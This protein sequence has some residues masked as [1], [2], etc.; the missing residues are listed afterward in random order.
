M[1]RERVV[2]LVGGDAAA[3]GEAARALEDAG[4]RAAVFVGDPAAADERAALVEMVE[5]L[6]PD[7]FPDA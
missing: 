6:F 2:V 7:A 5:E 3:L 4:I 1:T